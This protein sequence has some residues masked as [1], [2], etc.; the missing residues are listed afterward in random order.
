MG[1]TELT[2]NEEAFFLDGYAEGFVF[3]NSGDLVLHK[4]IWGAIESSAMTR[5]Y[6]KENNLRAEY[7]NSNSRELMALNLGEVNDRVTVETW[8]GDVNRRYVKMDLFEN[9]QGFAIQLGMTYETFYRLSPMATASLILR[10]YKGK[11][12]E[13]GCDV[14]T[15]DKMVHASL[16]VPDDDKSIDELF[17]GIETDYIFMDFPEDNISMYALQRIVVGNHTIS[18]VERSIVP[19]RSHP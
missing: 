4:P 19:T 8:I 17:K 12:V 1:L 13:I 14:V 2:E 9:F 6:L 10:D 18:Q 5:F 16:I 7:R 15:A 3:K 11:F